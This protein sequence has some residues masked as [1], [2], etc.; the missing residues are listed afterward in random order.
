MQYDTS[1]CQ[2]LCFFVKAS[3]AI[4]L[5]CKSVLMKQWADCGILW[6]YLSSW[7]HV[8]VFLAVY[9]PWQ[10]KDFFHFSQYISF[11]RGIEEQGK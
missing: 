1:L 3:A 10:E 2:L 8:K 9:M 7:G 6:L 11:Q 5:F 4:C